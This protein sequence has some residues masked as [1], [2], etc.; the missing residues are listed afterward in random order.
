MRLQRSRDADD[1]EDIVM[2]NSEAYPSLDGF[3]IFVKPASILAYRFSLYVRT[4]RFRC[5]AYRLWR[6]LVQIEVRAI[7][8]PVRECDK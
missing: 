3:C 6:L 4:K 5:F 1:F 7:R 2:T 8:M